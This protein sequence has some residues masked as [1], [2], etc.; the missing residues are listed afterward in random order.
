MDQPG[1][2][3]GG[4]AAS[5]SLAVAVDASALFGEAG[6]EVDAAVD[7][8][9]VWRCEVRS[10]QVQLLDAGRVIKGNVAV[11]LGEH[12]DHPANLQVREL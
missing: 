5:A 10:W 12:V 8:L 3:D 4:A 2:G 9:Y 6:D 1:K 7:G 11:P